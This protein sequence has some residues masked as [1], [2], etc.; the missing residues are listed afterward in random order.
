MMFQFACDSEASPWGTIVAQQP[1]SLVK[2]MGKSW[3]SVLL[4][5]LTFFGGIIAIASFCGMEI[6]L[7]WFLE[8]PLSDFM[9]MRNYG[10]D[11]SQSRW[12]AGDGAE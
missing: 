10:I 5:G 4:A 7:W 2:R 12:A 1:V 3:Q 11:F 8:S 9:D 6:T